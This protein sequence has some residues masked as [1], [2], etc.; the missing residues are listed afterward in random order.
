MTN[1]KEQIEILRARILA[2]EMREA[3]RD[4]LLSE[5]VQKLNGVILFCHM[6]NIEIAQLIGDDKAPPPSNEG[7]V[8]DHR[9][10]T[11]AIE[12]EFFGKTKEKKDG[13]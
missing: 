7:I 12:M 8:S 1:E 11:L 3:E 4:S 5:I 13:N 6:H 10:R 2:L 9:A